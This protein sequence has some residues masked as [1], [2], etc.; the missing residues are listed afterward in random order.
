MLDCLR[1]HG[2]L[3]AVSSLR[4]KGMKSLIFF[5]IPLLKLLS[6]STFFFNFLFVC[7]F[8]CVSG[9]LF[10]CCCCCCCC[11][12]QQVHCLRYLEKIFSIKHFRLITRENEF[13]PKLETYILIASKT[14]FTGS[15]F[16][17]CLRFILRDQKR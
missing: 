9:F 5:L 13:G 4:L 10:C 2:I 6:F 8:V 15:L 3:K 12:H 14:L 11:F 17:V 7:L 16:V 1:A